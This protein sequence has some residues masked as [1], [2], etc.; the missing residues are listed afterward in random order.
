MDSIVPVAAVAQEVLPV[1]GWDRISQST[2]SRKVSRNCRTV[3]LLFLQFHGPCSNATIPGSRSEG[4]GEL[5]Y[6]RTRK[7]SVPISERFNERCSCASARALRMGFVVPLR[8][9]FS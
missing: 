6:F 2:V 1:N 9:T 7:K 4:R 3:R 8:R 5:F